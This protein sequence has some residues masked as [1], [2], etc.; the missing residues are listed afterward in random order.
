MP[1]IINPAN[2]EVLY[3]YD[4]ITREKLDEKII[5][6][7]SAFAIWKKTSIE[8][9][10]KKFKKLAEIM[11]EKKEELA[12]IDTLEMG[13]LFSWALWDISKSVQGILYVIDKTQEWISPIEFNEWWISW[14]RIF[15]PM[16]VIYTVSP[17]NFPYNQVFRNATS[18]IMAWNVIL[19]KHASNVVWVARKIEELFLEAGFPEW[20][21]Q[22]IE[23]NSSESEYIISH[24][25]IKGVNIT[26]WDF[27]WRTVWK[28][29]GKYIKPSILELGWNDPFIVLDTQ[30]LD[31][32]VALAQVWRLSSCGQ[33][34]NSSK[35]FIIVEEY[36]DEFCKKL[37]Q[38]FSWL[39][40]GDPFD[41]ETIIGP[42]A[43]ESSIIDL[44]TLLSETVEKGWKILTWGFKVGDKW[45][46][47][48]PTVVADIVPGMSLFDEEVFWPIASVVKARDVNHAIELANNSRFGLTSAVITKNKELFEKVALEL[49]TGNVFHNKI[50]T[51]YP[52]L[53]YGWVKDSGYWKELW[54]RWMKNFMNEK[55]IVY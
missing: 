46:Y 14:K 34:C 32:T 8:E 50:P 49:E 10:A 47:Y 20:L 6:A 38:L 24:K 29:A 16:G 41:S 31:S 21:Y 18:N 55:V 13:M 22:N 27:A 51:S 37:A 4:Y 25:S 15:E 23:I 54:E 36:Y 1:K 26:G 5:K 35:K 30:D 52:F 19:S 48:S 7:E 3:S 42:L 40:I 11:L 9:R 53:P 44:N 17:W 2:S 43:K 33:K 12:R 45:V 28:L 39:K